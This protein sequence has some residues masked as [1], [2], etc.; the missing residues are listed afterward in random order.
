M[1]LP[2]TV[3]HVI[4]ENSPLF[5]HTHDS[6]VNCGAEIVVAFEWCIDATGLSFSARQSYLPSEILWG[7]TFRKGT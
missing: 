4:D 1:L 5:R 7:H 3:E 6:L 2:I